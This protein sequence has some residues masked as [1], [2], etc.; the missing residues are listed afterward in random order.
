MGTLKTLIVR[1]LGAEAESIGTTGIELF[2][3]IKSLVDPK[4]YDEVGSAGGSG[5][6]SLGWLLKQ[7]FAGNVQDAG[8]KWWE[9]LTQDGV[10]AQRIAYFL[11]L[12]GLS[13]IAQKSSFLNGKSDTEKLLDWLGVGW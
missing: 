11:G 9:N 13:R 5:A 6:P 10:P 4:Y 3:N 2:T 1:I 7:A 12:K 8:T